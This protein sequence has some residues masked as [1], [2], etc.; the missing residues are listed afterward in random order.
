MRNTQQPWRI[1]SIAKVC[2]TTYV[3]THNFIKSCESIG[4]VSVEKHGKIKDVK[5]TEKGAK[6]AEMIAGIYL[7]LAQQTPAKPD[8]EKEKEKK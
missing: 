1:A 4:I 2:E 5:L 7:I 8:E 6:V 3:H